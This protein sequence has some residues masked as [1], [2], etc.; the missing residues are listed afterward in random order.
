[1]LYLD[2]MK[3]PSEAY[4]SNNLFEVGC[5]YVV[6]SRFK[7]NGRVEA[8]F[9]LLD[10]FCLGVK[11]AGFEPFSSY[12][13]FESDLLDPLFAV[14]APVRMKPESGRKLVEDA[15]AYARQLSFAP[16]ADYKEASRVFGGISKSDCAEVFTF[17]KYGKPFYIQGTYESAAKSEHIL[18]ALEARCGKDG[19]HFIVGADHLGS[20]FDAADDEMVRAV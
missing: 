9:F 8:G 1:M 2:P 4:R 19:F 11:D 20:E 14:N 7:A 3:R 15:V 6:V 17:G 16:A 5:G 13:E 10:V 12:E 18:R